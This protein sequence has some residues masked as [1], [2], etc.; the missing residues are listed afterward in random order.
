MSTLADE[1]I[2]QIVFES[3][4]R[5]YPFRSRVEPPLQ[6]LPNSNENCQFSRKLQKYLLGTEMLFAC[7][8]PPSQMFLIVPYSEKLLGGYIRWPGAEFWCTRRS[9]VSSSPSVS[10]IITGITLSTWDTDSVSTRR[11]QVQNANSVPAIFL[12]FNVIIIIFF[13]PI[14]REE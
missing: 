3:Y 9:L 1:E 5:I 4:K 13:P 14:C 7:S 11:S 2:R 10:R 8:S 12:S 6:W